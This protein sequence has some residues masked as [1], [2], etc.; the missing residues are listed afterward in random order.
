MN[1]IQFLNDNNLE[2]ST[3]TTVYYMTVCYID[4]KLLQR[5]KEGELSPNLICKVT[6]VDIEK[7]ELNITEEVVKEIIVYCDENYTP[8]QIFERLVKDYTFIKGRVFT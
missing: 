1:Y 2:V 5:F 8:C 3:K 6:T 4:A 7:Q